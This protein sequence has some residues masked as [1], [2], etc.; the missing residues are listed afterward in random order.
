[1]T[2]VSTQSETRWYWAWAGSLLTLTCGA[3]SFALSYGYIYDVATT[4]G[5]KDAE[6]MAFVA[7]FFA[8]ITVI[9]KMKGHQLWWV[10]ALVAGLTSAMGMHARIGAASTGGQVLQ[11][12]AELAE[13][14][15]ALV[16]ATA[17]SSAAEIANIPEQI[18]F[19]KARLDAAERIAGPL[20]EQ[21]A[22][23]RAQLACEATALPEGCVGLNNN[24][25]RVASE[26][27]N[28][29][30]LN[31]R[32]NGL[33]CQDGVS[34]SLPLSEQL[35]RAERDLVQAGERLDQLRAQAKTERES[36]KEKLE[37][38][39]QAKDALEKVKDN[40][41]GA[42][43]MDTWAAFT[44]GLWKPWMAV[45]LAGFFALL[46]DLGGPFFY[47]GFPLPR[48]GWKWPT[49]PPAIWRATVWA[50]LKK[51]PTRAWRKAFTHQD[52]TFRNRTERWAEQAASIYKSGVGV[53][54]DKAQALLDDMGRPNPYRLDTSMAA[55]FETVQ[56]AKRVTPK[57]QLDLGD[58]AFLSD[59]KS[60][61]EPQAVKF[62]EDTPT[63]APLPEPDVEEIKALP[64]PKVEA[65]E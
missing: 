51:D 10:F 57:T 62:P 63:P 14:A 60:R 35:G 64:A 43:S 49:R 59:V 52:W 24:P 46:V 47:G 28:W 33:N 34:V 21:V 11:K 45:P 13:Q 32:L 19:A 40:G 3:L 50:L 5:W 58:L 17:E 30:E 25:V 29:A 39:N 18:E 31:C 65:A 55:G 48:T 56:D 27:P 44:F 37:Q 15:A 1:M 26:G 8:V 22:I 54:R 20:R 38:I 23:Y 2:A 7:G 9:S 16:G 12:Q 6:I 4:Q 36:A 61:P 53:T 41:L 42:S